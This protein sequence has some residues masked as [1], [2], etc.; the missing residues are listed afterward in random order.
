MPI[1]NY[2]FF[3]SNILS[4][5]HICPY[6]SQHCFLA[7][8]PTRL[9]LLISGIYTFC[10]GFTDSCFQLIMIY[11]SQTNPESSLSHTIKFC[12]ATQFFNC[13]SWKLLFP[14]RISKSV[15][16]DLTHFP[17][18]HFQAFSI[19]DKRYFY[20]TDSTDFWANVIIQHW[21][22]THFKSLLLWLIIS[23]H[24]QTQP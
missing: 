4:Q 15:P 6:K 1:S 10:T 19:L 9:V 20:W 12:L 22:L 11:L 21:Y 3:V 14:N 7:F 2:S 18:S 23:V 8:S 16:H 17:K 13:L 24:Y 5:S